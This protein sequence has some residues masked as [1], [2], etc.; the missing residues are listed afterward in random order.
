M[1]KIN[2]HIEIVSSS[3]PALS[4]MSEASRS[5]IK[6]SLE[7]SYKTAGIT[8]VDSKSDLEELVQKKPDMVFLG[9][10]S[11]PR[12]PTAAKSSP[13][14]WL[15]DYLNKNHILYT[16]SAVD[17]VMLECDKMKA[18]KVVKKADLPTAPFFMAY[19]GQFTSESQLV[20]PFPLFIKPPKLGAGIGIDEFSVARNYREY[21]T[22]I[23]KLDK[24]L[25]SESLIETY[26]TGREFTVAILKNA[27]DEEYQVMPLE[28]I[29]DENKNGDSI[30]GFA[31]KSSEAGT[32][33]AAITDQTL[34]KEISDLALECFKALGA[35][36]YGRI[37]IRCND[38]GS[39][40]FLEANLI[41]GL[42][43][44]SSYF[45]QSCEVNSNLNYD[46]VIKRIVELGFEGHIPYVAP[47]IVENEEITAPASSK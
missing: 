15:A 42:I 41:P 4:W 47:V 28:L 6:S 46:D 45:Q 37:D 5:A 2:K 20:L 10:K 27:H 18:K 25:D 26:L 19:T 30:I 31:T 44:N 24:E 8:I 22:K 43:E 21:K 39:P 13:H 38:A 16:G 36:D 3:D 35:K 29:P 40:F 7:K 17:A 32:T 9:M 14:I 23:A 33:V 12:N 1:K 11:L 34:K